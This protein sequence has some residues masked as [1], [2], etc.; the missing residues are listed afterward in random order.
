MSLAIAARAMLES[1]AS[2][3]QIV[4][5]LEKADAAR[6]EAAREGNASRQAAFKARQKAG[7]AVTEPINGDGDNGDNGVTNTHIYIARERAP[8]FSNDFSNEKSKLYTPLP[9]E[10]PQS[11]KRKSGTCL[12]EDWTPPEEL[13]AYGAEQGLT[14][15]QTASILEDMRIWAVSNRNRAVARKADWNLTA[16]GFIRRDAKRL[17][18]RAG[19]N[20]R[21]GFATLLAESL[22]ESHVERTEKKR[23]SEIVQLLPISEHDRSGASG[24]HDGGVSRNAVEVLVGNSFRR[25]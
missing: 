18:A 4:L 20:G 19:P 11:E 16:K 9:S 22:A 21:G 15:S 2:A 7:N 1:G 23:T 5:M 25:M 17:S 3:E 12:P 14:R 6:R 13:F 8:G 10:G 24:D